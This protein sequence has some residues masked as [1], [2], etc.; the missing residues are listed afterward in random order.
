MGI[1]E[2][3]DVDTLELDKIKDAIS[4]ATKAD[5]KIVDIQLTTQPDHLCL[6]IVTELR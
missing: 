3:L 2:N 4:W 1:T 6:T 5:V